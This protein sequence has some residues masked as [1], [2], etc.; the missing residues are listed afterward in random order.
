MTEGLADKFDFEIICG[1]PLVVTEKSSSPPHCKI[2][3]VPTLQLPKSLLLSRALNDLSFLFSAFFRGLFLPCPNLVVSQTSPPG[4]WWVAFFLSRWHRRKWIHISQDSFPE[5]LRILMDGK[6]GGLLSLLERM[7]AFILR[8]SERIVVIG[9][10]MKKGFLKRGFSSEKIVCI[11]NWSDLEF[12]RPVPKKNF[13]SEKNDIATKFVVLYA[14]NFGRIH[15]FED[16][17][18]A[19]E[20]LRTRPEIQF[21]FVGEGALK[22]QLIREVQFR[23]LS[24][25]KFL[26]FEPR[27]ELPKILASADVSVI[28]LRKGMAG[29]SVPSKIYSILASGRPILACVEEESD[30][31]KMVRESGSGF[32]I[33]PGNSE[34]FA[35]AI[36]SLSKNCDK[37]QRMG[38]NAR[39]YIETMDFKNRALRGYGELFEKSL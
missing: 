4:I 7:N 15:N 34:A 19:A 35:Q 3:P 32:V 10:D 2:H 9:E 30:I 23:E 38:Q 13:F 21:V 22:P 36:A 28:L 16:L 25:V 18:G 5:N 8:K 1:P 31:A 27:S 37:T 24:N 14:G 6:Y 26:P 12:I 17:L 29:L 20:Q 39:R 11:F 33:L